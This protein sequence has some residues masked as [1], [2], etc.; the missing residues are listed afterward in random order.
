MTEPSSR[1]RIT[2]PPSEADMSGFPGLLLLVGVAASACA[3][4][5][6]LPEPIPLTQLEIRASQTRTYAGPDAQTVV[7]TL[8]NVLQDDGFLVHY[9]DLELGLL[10]ASKMVS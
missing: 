10:D 3:F 6:R 7:K 9:G 1:C 2:R 5:R 4:P 8:L